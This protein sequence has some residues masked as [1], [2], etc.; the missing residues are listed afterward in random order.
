MPRNSND[1]G[2]ALD[3]AKVQTTIISSILAGMGQVRCP[4]TSTQRI[5]VNRMVGGWFKNHRKKL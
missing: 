2:M 1:L 3:Y 4:S 5:Y